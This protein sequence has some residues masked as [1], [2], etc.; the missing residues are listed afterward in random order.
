MAE[1][2]QKKVLI[3]EDDMTQRSFF[4]QNLEAW[5]YVVQTAETSQAMQECLGEGSVDI[6]LLDNNLP[7]GLGV[8]LT[9]QLAEEHPQTRI[10]MVTGDTDVDTVVHA[11]KNGCYDFMA[12]P[13]KMDRLRNTL[14][15]A[16]QRMPLL[17][18]EDSAKRTRMIGHTP[19]MKRINEAI[20]KVAGSDCS[21]LISGETGTGK[22]LVAR[23]IHEKSSR[24]H[25]EMINLNLAAIPRELVESAT[26]GP[27]KGAFTGAD[28]QRIGS[29]EMA[30]GSTLFLDE[31]AEMDIS[32]Q[33]KLLRF[34]ENQTFHR[35]GGTAPVTV[36]TRLVCATNHEPE[37]MLARQIMREDLFYRIN[38][39]HIELPPLRERRVDIP[40]LASYYMQCAAEAI[41]REF[42]D[43]DHEAMQHLTTYAWPGNIRQ[44]KNVISGMVVMHAGPIITKNMLPVE[45][46][47]P[48]GTT[49][50][51][52]TPEGVRPFI[53]IEKEVM[54]AALDACKGNVTEAAQRLKISRATMYRKIKEFDLTYK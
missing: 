6:I 40:L 29:A 45:I 34:L 33:P 16:T 38:V 5:G 17:D 48:A 53:E 43:I 13:V 42:T 2:Q 21:G 10:I 51:E 25:N 15:E 19:A 23:A 30:N 35:I 11:M 47:T 26:L 1:K 44:L 24:C 28:N 31:I 36:D 12:K 50:Q 54:Q 46:R 22:E 14:K 49:P 37:E 41:D 4:Q 52:E 3:V 9:D 8:K 7:D 18:T 39:V 27:E 20:R 32:L